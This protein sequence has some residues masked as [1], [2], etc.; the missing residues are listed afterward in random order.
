MVFVIVDDIYSV[1]FDDFLFC[2]FYE[3][4]Y[5]YCVVFVDKVYFGV[6]VDLG[7]EYEMIGLGVKGEV[8]DVNFIGSFNIGRKLVF[9]CIIVMN[10]SLVVFYIGEFSY[11]IVI[12]CN[13][14]VVE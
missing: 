13:N 12:I 14:K 9:Y 3:V 11:C 8:K 10:N 7:I 5:I 1:C 4:R 2:V 6:C